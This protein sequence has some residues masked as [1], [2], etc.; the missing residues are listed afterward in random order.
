M[1]VEDPKLAL[2]T[3]DLFPLVAE[4]MGM[5]LAQLDRAVT[6]ISLGKDLTIVG[7]VES[8]D[9]GRTFKITIP[10]GLLVFHIRMASLFL[11]RMSIV[12][13][14]GTVTEDTRIAT[15]E[16][17]DV[18]KKTMK[19]F[20]RSPDQLI[21]SQG[22]EYAELTKSQR[23][24]VAQVV[25]YADT[26][27]VAHE[28]GHAIAWAC[29][30]RVMKDELIVDAAI[31]SLISPDLEVPKNSNEWKPELLADCIAIQLCLS[32]SNNQIVKIV[33]HA[34]AILSLLTY[35][36]LEKGYEQVKGFPWRTEIYPPST[37]RLDFIQSFADWP[38]RDNLG[39][40]FRQICDFIIKRS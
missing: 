13:D 23:D 15:D 18:A 2:I 8:P 9:N 5:S 26:F 38:G 29:P 25:H 16:M 1:N 40:I 6:D 14:F 28:L 35:Y 32:L 30:D 12:D 10:F 21:L 34:S 27:V 36:M 17:V 7:E 24:L 31:N 3:V 39:T 22:L 4:K 33:I 20:W 37:L 11:S 19:D